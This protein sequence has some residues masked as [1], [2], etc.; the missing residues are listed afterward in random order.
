MFNNVDKK[1]M[2][3][4]KLF[5]SHVS[6]GKLIASSL[7]REFEHYNLIPFVAHE[8]IEPTEIWQD[9]I[10]KFLKECDC[11]L[12]LHTTGYSESI[13]CNQEAGYA[14]GKS[15]PHVSVRLGEDPIGFIGKWQAY[16]PKKPINYPFVANKIIKLIRKQA[17][18]SNAIRSWIISSFQTSGSFDET[19]DLCDALRGLKLTELELEVI[20]LS[21]MENSQV[22]GA[23]N[24]VNILPQEWIDMNVG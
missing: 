21:Y 18:E 23:N 7:A 6:P 24:I 19:N 1:Q 9:A 12:I 8:E 3:T 2:T 13:W 15:I 20:K 4:L 5:I 22:R 10:E 11:M 14:L 17:S 16:T